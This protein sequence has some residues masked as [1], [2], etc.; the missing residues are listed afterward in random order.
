MFAAM[1]DHFIRQIK[2]AR[3]FYVSQY[4]QIDRVS[5]KNIKRNQFGAIVDMYLRSLSSGDMSFFET[6]SGKKLLKYIE[7]VVKV[8]EVET[9]NR[10]YYNV[11]INRKRVDSE[12]NELNIE[13]AAIEYEKARQ[14]VD[15]H[16]NNA[17]ISLLIRFESFLTDYFEWLVK[18]YPNKYLNE[19]SI[20]Y[21]ELIK[22]DLENLKKELSVEAANGIMS[23][24]L[25]EW[26][27]VIKSHKFDL[28]TLSEYLNQ[29]TE[30]YYRRNLIVHNNGKVNRQ[31]LAGIKKDE[32]EHPLGEKLV[33]DR[34]Y[35]LDAFNVSMVI[36][37]G[38]LYASSKGNKD[39]GPEYLDFLFSSGFDHMMENNWLVS[40]YI[41]ELLINDDTQDEINSTLSQIN[42]WISYKNMGRFKDVKEAIEAKDF[43]AMNISIRMAKEML[44]ENYE[45]AIPLLDEALL[46]GMTPNMVETWPLFIQFRKTKCYEEFRRKYAKELEHQIINP[47][48][49]NESMD[50]NKADELHELRHALGENAEGTEENST[51]VSKTKV[52]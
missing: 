14:M 8:E 35:V 9:P 1:A 39:D 24:P 48:D 15:I 42:Y 17:L 7:S 2:I 19:K 52:T 27:K 20:R 33:T 50:S 12:K 18:K 31:Y 43:S 37:Y 32:A 45:V 29:F 10:H 34:Q 16:N 30:I 49:L 46:T 47:E 11:A 26:L 5:K 13:K 22:F 6:E 21:S 23:Q 44:L 3:Y 40:S 38:L 36:V 28:S 41:F 4:K 25:D 51:D